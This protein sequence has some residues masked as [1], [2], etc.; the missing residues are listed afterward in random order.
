MPFR[1]KLSRQPPDPY[2]ITHRDRLLAERPLCTAARMPTGPPMRPGRP[3]ANAC[4]P[5]CSGARIRASSCVA[6]AMNWSVSSGLS[7]ALLIS[8]RQDGTVTCRVS[9]FGLLRHHIQT[10]SWQMSAP[11]EAEFS[12]YLA[13]ER[14]WSTWPAAADVYSLGAVLYELV[15]GVAAPLGGKVSAVTAG[16]A[17]MPRA[18]APAHRRALAPDPAERMASITEFA[19]ALAPFASGPF[20]ELPQ[21]LTLPEGGSGQVPRA[22]MLYPATEPRPSWSRPCEPRQPQLPRTHQPAPRCRTCAWMTTC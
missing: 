5:Q 4:P 8:R 10:H 9:D 22:K 21:G 17:Q 19:D 15:F 14:W 16:E 13:P 2:L 6:A 18:H 20:G 1:S 12:R 3:K 7:G 11:V